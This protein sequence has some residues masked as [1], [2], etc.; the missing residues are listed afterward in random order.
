M[1]DI[2]IF[3]GGLSGL[4]LAHELI[5]KKFKILI[6]EKDNELGGMARSNRNKNLYPSEHSWR[7]YGPF[8]KNTFQLMK[9]IPYY[10]TN[11]FNNL[12][13]PIEFYLLYDKEYNYKTLLSIKDIII[14]YYIAINY[15][16]SDI[17]R[18]YYYSY[19]IEPF[20]KK[21]LTKDGYNFMINFIGGPGYGMN[22][23]ELSMGH[24]FHFPVISQINKKKHTHRHS[25]DGHEYEH[26]S[27]EN[28]HVMNGPTSDVWIEPW[29]KYLKE[30]GVD[31][32]TNTE[33]IKINHKK[34]HISFV[35]VKQNGIIYQLK[36]K[37][38]ILSI[39]P[40]NTVDILRKSK[41]QGL[42]N[43]FKSL[44]DNTKSKQISFRIGINKE[45]MYPINNIAFVM[46]DSEFKITWYPQEKHWKHKPG[47]KSLWSGTIVDF[48]EKGNLFNKNAEHLDNEELKKEIIYQILRS[49]S[50]QKLIYDNNGFYLNKKDIDYTE[51]WYEWKFYNGKQEQLNKKWVNDIYNEEFRPLQKTKYENLFL[52][53]AHTKTT[54]NLW[55]M[56][57]AIESGK[58]T[59]NYILDKYNKPNIEHYK[60]D[61]PFYIKLIQYIDNILY[62]LYLPNIINLLIIL[63]LFFI[64]YKIYIINAKHIKKILRMVKMGRYYA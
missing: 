39:N 20:L 5:K 15:L 38:Y 49:K 56:E 1:Y 32:W 34:D 18:E 37:E 59:A 41:M 9:E 53:G 64:L 4:T 50:F 21:Y 31:I 35:E 42:Y 60:H 29:V 26:H 30:K 52:S 12:S 63:I 57:G 16:L 58:I 7:G 8:Y 25:S 13:I 14:I 24:L 3:G 36:A 48:E 23:N 22:K 19:N 55:S 62:K 10:D 11:V 28:W 44:T 43:N 61:A 27:D 40:F 33:L 46:V 45:I 17:R 51:I 2:I 6:I 54:I 47:M